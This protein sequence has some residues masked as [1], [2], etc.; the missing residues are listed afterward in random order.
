MSL[1]GASTEMGWGV[2]DNE[3][4]ESLVEAKLNQELGGKAYTKYEILNLAVPGYYPLQQAMV[5]EKALSFR[6]HAVLYM[7]SGRELSRSAAYLAEAVNK[8]IELPY[9]GLKEVATAAGLEPGMPEDEAVRRLKPFREKLLSWLYEKIV[10]DVEPKASSRCGC[11]SRRFTRERGW[12][13]R[14]PRSSWPRNT[15]F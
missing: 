2:E 6:P 11:S 3:T 15:D 8:R 7:A 12:K 9:P 13:R 1:L 14:V 5:V 4:Y 10:T